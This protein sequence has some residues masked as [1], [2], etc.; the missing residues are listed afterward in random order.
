MP[1]DWKALSRQPLCAL[2]SAGFVATVLM[3]LVA[4]APRDARA[5]ERS[6]VLSP[7]MALSWEF[8]VPGTGARA[9]RNLGVGFWQRASG[10]K[11]GVGSDY[12]STMEYQLPEAAPG[13]VRHATFQFSGRP[14]QCVGNEPVVIEV[15]GY[16]GN[17]KSEQGDASAGSPVARMSA[18]CG[19]QH[20]F[21]QPVD[22][23]ALVRQLTV[24]S[25]VRHIGF[26]V[27]KGNHRQGAGLFELA[28]GKLTV[29]ISDVAMSARAPATPAAAG[30]VAQPSAR[31]SATP[32]TSMPAAA[33]SAHAAMATPAT[34]P[35][36]TAAKPTATGSATTAA[37]H[38]AP[39]TPGSTTK[40]VAEK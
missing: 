19:D 30:V 9:R 28:P 25:G 4:V 2:A 40:K 31:T 38:A 33:P 13:Q 3:L 35:A 37:T 24:A 10:A 27:R 5:A 29:V 32:S 34:K 15:L 12:V 7:V 20:A 22:V 8:V 18:G 14:S 11:P 1:I 17:G 6:I 26:A 21:T 23:T 39:T 36:P 16:A